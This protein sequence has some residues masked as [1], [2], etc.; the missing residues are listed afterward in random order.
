[1]A[2]RHC[3]DRKLSRDWK[4]CVAGT[5]EGNRPWE[6]FINNNKRR[7]EKSSA[8]DRQGGVRTQKEQRS[9]PEYRTKDH[10]EQESTGWVPAGPPLPS[11]RK[12]ASDLASV[13]NRSG[14]PDPVSGGLFCHPAK[15]GPAAV[16]IAVDLLL[17][18]LS[19]RQS[20]LTLRQA[21]EVDLRPTC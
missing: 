3:C 20:K 21:Q 11:H 10:S 8:W 17:G 2:R 13:L 14:T 5:H 4:Q 12:S 19:M 9:P 6:D 16:I 1:M 7:N 18:F 15:P